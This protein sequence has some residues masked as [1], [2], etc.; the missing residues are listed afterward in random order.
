VVDTKGVI[1]AS[2]RG[3]RPECIGKVEA[4]VRKELEARADAG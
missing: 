1:R 4:E 3:Y 2:F